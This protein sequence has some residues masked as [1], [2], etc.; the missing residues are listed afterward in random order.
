MKEK[1][2]VFIYAAIAVIITFALCLGACPDFSE[3]DDDGGSGVVVM[4]PFDDW[5][6]NQL[7]D[8]RWMTILS[9]I[10]KRGRKVRLDLSECEISTGAKIMQNVDID[11]DGNI[12]L[13]KDRVR[14]RIAFI[15]NHPDLLTPPAI[16]GQGLIESIILPDI[17]GMI[18]HADKSPYGYEIEIREEVLSTKSVFRYFTRLRSISGK[19]VQLIGNFSFFN[20]KTLEEVN[21]PRTNH[22]NEGAFFG[23][24]S[25]REVNFK[26]ALN[27]SIRA[28]EGCT[29]LRKAD[30][31][32]LYLIDAGAFKGCASL[33]NVYFPYVGRI[34]SYAFM[35]CSSLTE[36]I[37]PAATV[38]GK[39]SFR[40]CT[41]LEKAIFHANP[42]SGDLPFDPDEKPIVINNDHDDDN[43]SV[44]FYELAFSGCRNLKELDV[45]HAWN[46]YFARSALADIGEHLDLYMFDDDGTKS[47]GHPQTDWFLGGGLDGLTTLK[48]IRLDLPYVGSATKVEN[49]NQPEEDDP[50]DYNPSLFG[51]YVYIESTYKTPKI[52]VNITRRPPI[53]IT[54]NEPPTPP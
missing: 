17:V 1:K 24:T 43:T 20:K 15:P 9:D 35:G 27:I 53:T 7:S 8:L 29:G 23:C 34:N 2:P 36:V 3:E 28:F 47:F 6:D 30:I 25:L 49:I 32:T 45:R 18:P 52:D 5:P 50:A 48:S 51:I 46:V 41:R 10:E 33:A 14:S 38:I 42:A 40:N 39:E 16:A 12:V 21:F 4:R 11:G 19:N 31:P 44:F 26:V 37:F 54:P 13:P 22:I